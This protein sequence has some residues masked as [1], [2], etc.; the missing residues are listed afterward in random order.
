VIGRLWHPKTTAPG[1]VR[2]G[3]EISGWTLIGCDAGPAAL[4]VEAPESTASIDTAAMNSIMQIVALRREGR[5][6][7][8]P[9]P[10]LQ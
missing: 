6:I 2:C 5:M 1:A 7:F 9:L 3:V 10:P 4:D 8:T